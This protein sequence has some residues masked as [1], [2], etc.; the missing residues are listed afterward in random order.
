MS[1]RSLENVGAPEVLKATLPRSY[2]V[3][4]IPHAGNYPGP[5]H[6]ATERFEP[7][8]IGQC[9]FESEDKIRRLDL[10]VVR[11][12]LRPFERVVGNFASVQFVFDRPALR[13][14]GSHVAIQTSHAPGQVLPGYRVE[15]L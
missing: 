8:Q 14:V 4:W 10:W 11:A 5:W 12:P 15:K 1:D 6:D 2:G 9:V 7:R 13:D 3:E